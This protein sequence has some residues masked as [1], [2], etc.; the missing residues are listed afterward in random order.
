M[1]GMISTQLI[2]MADSMLGLDRVEMVIAEASG[3]SGPCIRF[4]IEKQHPPS[5]VL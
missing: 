3:E 2:E 4:I 5:H 1:K